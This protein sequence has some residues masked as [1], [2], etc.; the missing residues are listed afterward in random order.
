[1]IF[2][3]RT[4]KILCLVLALVMLAIP[5]AS[6]ADKPILKLEDE[7]LSPNVYKFLLS[8][9]KGALEDMGYKVS[10]PDFW[11]TIVS[12]NGMTYGDYMK[13]EV[14]RQAYSYIVT[15]YLFEKEGLTLPKE[16]TDN[17]E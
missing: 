10:S 12:A 7:E 4:V 13:A 14:L 17:I 5:L 9:M 11:N 16:T 15:D 2:K 1:M 3:K 6:C 8:R